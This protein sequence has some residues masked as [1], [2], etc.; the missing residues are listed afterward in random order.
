MSDY[1][2]LGPDDVLREGD[3]QKLREPL[4]KWFPVYRERIGF[5]ATSDEGWMFRRPRHAL[6]RDAAIALLRYALN[7]C[8]PDS[9]MRL[10]ND[11]LW[12]LQDSIGVTAEELRGGE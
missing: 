3:E 1:I 4:C 2:D 7:D 12:E 5:K 11:H 6:I 10:L 8:E 9:P